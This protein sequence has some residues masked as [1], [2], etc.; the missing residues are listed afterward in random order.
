MEANAL[1]MISLAERHLF[2]LVKF[3]DAEGAFGVFAMTARLAPKSRGEGNQLFWQLL[4]G[5][6]LIHKITHRGHLGRAGEEVAILRF[7]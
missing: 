5:H 3:V 1:L 6:Y 4:F 2:H 7:I